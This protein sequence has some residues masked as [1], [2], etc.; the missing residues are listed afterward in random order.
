MYGVVV[1]SMVFAIPIASSILGS[2][3]AIRKST[4]ACASCSICHEWN[5]SASDTDRPSSGL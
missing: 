3:S 4:P 2:V 5:I 1:F